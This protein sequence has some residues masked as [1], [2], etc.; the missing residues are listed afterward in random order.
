MV[1]A[2][3]VYQQIMT[4]AMVGCTESHHSRP[5]RGDWPNSNLGF[6]LQ[7]TIS[8]T[9]TICR[10]LRTLSSTIDSG[11]DAVKS[12]DVFIHLLACYSSPHLTFWSYEHNFSTLTTSWRPFLRISTVLA[13][14][15]HC[16]AAYRLTTVQEGGVDRCI[17][18]GTTA[19]WVN[20]YHI[21]L[22]PWIQAYLNFKTI[23]IRFHLLLVFFPLSACLDF[24]S[25]PALNSE[26]IV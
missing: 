22:F 7:R 21:L 16:M 17:W 4:I 20:P 23:R 13:W 5:T 19:W 15:M 6:G 11:A 2:V 3:C 18:I 1:A 9:V 10:R 26:R 24:A 12:V 25:P 8:V 14:V